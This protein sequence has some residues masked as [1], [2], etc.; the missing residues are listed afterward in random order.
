MSCI[1][2]AI[3]STAPAPRQQ[4]QDQTMSSGSD[5]GSRNGSGTTTTTT[6]G[7]SSNRSNRE[8]A[9]E[10]GPR[11]QQEGFQQ[12]V[13]Q[14]DAVKQNTQTVATCP[15]DSD[16]ELFL[17]FGEEYL[18]NPH[19]GFDELLDPFGP[20]RLLSHNHMPGKLQL[21]CFVS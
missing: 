16:T 17:D 4:S 5:V 10:N 18:N 3:P 1:Q 6:K 19:G 9:R 13:S 12:V 11:N 21:I 20:D 7:S 2:V 8:I 14:T 15:E